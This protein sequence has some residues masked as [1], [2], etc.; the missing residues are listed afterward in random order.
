MFWDTEMYIFPTLVL[1][2]PNLAKRLLRYRAAT[3]VQ[4]ENHAKKYGQEGLRSV[5]W[6]CLFV[7]DTYY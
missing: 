4:A 5:Y 6:F 3:Q 1:L 7:L 2:Q